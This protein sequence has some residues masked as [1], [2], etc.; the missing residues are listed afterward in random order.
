MREYIIDSSDRIIADLD[1]RKEFQSFFGKR[2]RLTVFRL[3]STKKGDGV[4][5]IKEGSA[6]LFPTKEAKFFLFILKYIFK[7]LKKIAI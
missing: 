7:P 4:P 3:R 2:K 5:P 1:S 6:N